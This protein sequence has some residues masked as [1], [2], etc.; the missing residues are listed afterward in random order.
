MES[1]IKELKNTLKGYKKI[2]KNYENSGTENLDFNEKECY[3]EYLGK[4][5][6]LEDIIPKLQSLK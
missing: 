4:V 2:I 1:L 3:G 6:L 5:E